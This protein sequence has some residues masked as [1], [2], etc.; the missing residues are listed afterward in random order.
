[1]KVTVWLVARERTVWVAAAE[2]V[3]LASLILV[4][5]ESTVGRLFGLAL[6]GHL[7]YRAV[8]GLPMGAVP[9]RPEGSKK[10]RQNQD[11]RTRVVGFLNEVR[12]VESYARRAQMAGRPDGEVRANIRA[13]QRRMMAAAA[14]VAKATGRVGAA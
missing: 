3:A 2:A 1:M 9:S 6:L 13:A 14:E 7:A 12:S 4:G 10:V 11:L 8:T 5:P